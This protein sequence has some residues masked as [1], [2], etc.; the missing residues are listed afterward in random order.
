MY[1]VEAG[2][3][4]G[5]IST[6]ATECDNYFLL[7]GVKSWVTSGPQ[8]RAAVIF[9]TINKELKHKGTV[10]KD[11]FHCFVLFLLA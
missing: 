2:S 9:A 10:T 8:G 7:N 11:S 6:T 5:A 4:V 1:F 3:D